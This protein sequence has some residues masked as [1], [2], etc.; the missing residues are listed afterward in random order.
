LVFPVIAMTKDE[1]IQVDLSWEPTTIEPNKNTKFIFTFRDAKTGDLLRNTTYDF[2]ILQNGKELYKKSANAQIG[3]D[4][5]DYT[6]S[7]Y[8]KGQTSIRFENL[9]GSDRS[10]E[11]N[12]FVVPEFGQL[13]LIMLSFAVAASLFIGNRFKI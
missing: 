7:E 9:R 10:T 3:S 13:V 6:F 4:F 1:Q 8:Q 11:F 12:I 2:L 5:A